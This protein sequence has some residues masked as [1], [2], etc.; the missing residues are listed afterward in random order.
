MGTEKAV[1]VGLGEIKASAA[2][3]E[4]L[5]CLGLGSCIC[6]AAFDP[7]AKVG[8]MAHIVLPESPAQGAP[9]SAKFADVAVPRLFETLAKTGGT[10]SRAV[11]K[12]AGG[13][14]MAQLRVRDDGVF[15]IGARNA[16]ATKAALQ[17]A[18]IRL[19]A[20]QTGGSAGRTVRLWIDSGRV[21]VTVVGQAPVVL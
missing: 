11:V 14:H 10:P 7:V 20:E 18:G 2:L 1:V 3:D 13:A 4:V 5:T 17:K 19:V 8:A 16:L 6:V 21:S 12:I 15:N 9:P